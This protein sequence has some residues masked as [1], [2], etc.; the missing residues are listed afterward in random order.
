ML[1]EALRYTRIG[2]VSTEKSLIALQNYLLNKNPDCMI[3]SL[4]DPGIIHLSSQG[5]RKE[6]HNR[7]KKMVEQL[8][9]K[10]RSDFA[11]TI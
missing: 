4:V 2:L 8:D 11:F 3:E 6:H 5:K 7:V 9:G 10:D 1:D